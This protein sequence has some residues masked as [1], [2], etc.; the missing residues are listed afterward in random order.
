MREIKKVGAALTRRLDNALVAQRQML[1]DLMKRRLDAFAI[2]QSS[3][4]ADANESTKKRMKQHQKTAESRVALI[5]NVVGEVTRLKLAFDD[6]KC[7]VD[8][9]VARDRSTAVANRAA[10]EASRSS[11]ATAIRDAVAVEVRRVMAA[12][13]AKER[14]R[15]DRARGSPLGRS[16]RGAR[17]PAAEDATA[18]AADIK[19]LKH[20]LE[21]VKNELRSVRQSFNDQRRCQTPSLSHNTRQVMFA[22][23]ALSPLRSMSTTPHYGFPALASSSTP[24]AVVGSDSAVKG[25]RARVRKL[26]RHVKAGDVTKGAPQQL[27]QQQ[28]QQ[29]QTAVAV[30]QIK[31]EFKNMKKNVAR[32]S[33]RVEACVAKCKV[34]E[35]ALRQRSATSQPSPN[36][37][38]GDGVGRAGRAATRT[39][40]PD[41]WRQVEPRQS[42]GGGGG[43]CY[44]NEHTL[45]CISYR[46][47][48]PAARGMEGAISPTSVKAK[49]TEIIEAHSALKLA[50]LTHVSGGSGADNT[51]ITMQT[52]AIQFLARAVQLAS[53]RLTTDL[54]V[55]LERLHVTQD[56]VVSL[57]GFAISKEAQRY[58][59][60]LSALSTELERSSQEYRNLTHAYKRLERDVHAASVSYFRRQEE[61]LRP[62]PGTRATSV[63]PGA[64][65]SNS[66]HAPAHRLYANGLAVPDELK[67]ALHRVDLEGARST[68]A[69]VMQATY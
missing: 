69:K 61:P 7:A 20:S 22:A 32:M 37:D 31:I 8:G 13:E 53:V 51:H 9:L 5:D 2:A 49:R 45:E 21:A 4:V 11:T 34:M 58:R 24:G 40:I 25:L 12:A 44:E 39:S 67:N 17:D 57:A 28:R 43:E 65:P 60:E 29:Q 14:A 50:G 30:A 68:Y 56:A 15:S 52:A 35:S 48:H 26:E 47:T 62:T 19:E 59:A 36:D 33:S 16:R 54:H 63:V 3:L 41:G 27:L 42:N 23:P 66:L 6:V 18:A 46:P 1:V 38:D 55:V 64:V 10:E